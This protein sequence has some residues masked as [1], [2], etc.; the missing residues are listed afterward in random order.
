MKIESATYPSK[1]GEITQYTLTNSKG[2]SVKLSSLGAGIAS[3]RVPDRDGKIEDVA[4]AY[5]DAASYIADG[6]CAGK[7]PGRVAN[8][9]AFGE[10]ELDGKIY[11][12]ARNNGTSALHGG[13]TGFQ[14]RIWDS[15]T[16]GDKVIFTYHSKDGEEGYP[17]NLTVKAEYTW[18]END[19]LTLRITAET[20]APTVVNLTNH[21]YF[22][23]E[24]EG[25]G[26][27]F[28]HELRLNAKN[29]LPTNDEQIPTGEIAPVE[30]TPMDFTEFKTIGRDINAGTF[31]LKIGKGYDHCWVAE[32]Y[33]P[34]KMKEMA[35]LRSPKSGRVLT[36]SST[37]PAMQV[38]TGNWL[39][40]APESISGGEYNDYDAVA[41]ECQCHPDAPHHTNFPSI[42]LRPGEL[43]DQTIKF[44]F[45]VY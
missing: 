19:E 29:W 23:L 25:A 45:S 9:I 7:I 11:H 44:D 12:L 5:K 2:A 6:P 31:A 32:D 27:I 30:G 16:E 26:K 37:Q 22:N 8:R 4:L 10:F 33:E 21:A 13:P 15:K 41:I 3:V 43:F 1:L 42:V 20:D 24:G 18:S 36:L 14:N 38:Y 35:V 40:G 39:T 17:G 34:G 28:D